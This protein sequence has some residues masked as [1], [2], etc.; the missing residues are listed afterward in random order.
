MPCYQALYQ[1][2]RLEVSKTPR[3]GRKVARAPRPKLTPAQKVALRLEPADNGCLNFTGSLRAGYGR[4]STPDGPR[5]A[6]RVLWQAERGP[7]DPSLDLDHLCRNRRCCNL[8]HLEPVTRSVNVTRGSS[9]AGGLA[10][11][12]HCVNG[13]EYSEE[14]TAYRDG[15]RG[16]VCR[17]C[18]KAR[19][20]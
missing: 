19:V 2:G 16:R 6:H 9:P 11:R 12:T 8:D 20:R 5:Q 13:H 14:N 7:L 18:S 3:T 15:Y 10:L 4:I 17:A 1:A